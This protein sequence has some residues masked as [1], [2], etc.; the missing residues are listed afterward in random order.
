MP[1][2]LV[3]RSQFMKKLQN[4]DFISQQITKAESRTMA[5][6]QGRIRSRSS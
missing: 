4:R 3:D 1:F 6:F 2:V 5:G